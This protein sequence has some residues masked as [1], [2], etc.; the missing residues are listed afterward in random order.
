MR[1][2]P[3]P[4]D[5]F[6]RIGGGDIPRSKGVHL[7]DIIR[8]VG[9][10]S[11]LWA[12]QGQ[13]DDQTY[14]RFEVGFMWEDLL[15]LIYANRAAR[16]PPEIQLD[17]IFGSPDG[18]TVDG[19]GL[20]VVEEYKCTWGSMNKEPDENWYWLMQMKGYC[21]MVGAT[22]SVL[23]VLYLNGDYRPPAPEYRAFQFDWSEQELAENWDIILRHKE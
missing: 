22:R 14:R 2:T 9:V 19:D 10:D 17:G 20:L 8:K 5:D 1:I 11:G 18:L 6:I 7:S 3:L 23:R 15:S 16:R 13:I 21:H 12:K 4:D